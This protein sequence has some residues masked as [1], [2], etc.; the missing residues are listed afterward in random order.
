MTDH[1]QPHVTLLNAILVA[2]G[3]RPDCRVW[4]QEVGL[5]LRPNSLT[6]VRPLPNGEPDIKG[7]LAPSGRTLAIEVKTGSGVPSDVQRKRLAMY[8]AMGAVAGV[9]RSVD[10]AVRAVEAAARGEWAPG[11]G[12]DL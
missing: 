1:T 10:Q 5:W 3:A 4:R 2:L 8:R 11:E 9:C 12:L 7:L 6:P